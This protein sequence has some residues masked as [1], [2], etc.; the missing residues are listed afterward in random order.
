LNEIEV[1]RVVKPHGIKGEVGVIMLNEQSNLLE[2]VPSV[3]AIGGDGARCVL[4][5]EQ[6]APMGR[7]YR[8]K[9]VGYD[10]RTS[11]ETL[12]NLRL[13]VPREDLPE[14]PDNE[15]YLVDLIGAL[16]FDPDGQLIGEVVEL[17]SYPSVEALVI[18]TPAGTSVEQPWVA[19]WVKS[20]D[21]A[22][23]RIVLSG[24]DGLL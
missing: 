17:Q 1:A 7:G 10:D 14:L 13:A 9:F 15:G 3:I 20:V 22:A 16:V 6:I 21:V 11:A 24:L 5:I 8:V 23:R 12:R 19:D 2:R 4:R 18:R